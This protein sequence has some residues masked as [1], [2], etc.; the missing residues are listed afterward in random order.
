MT[1]DD[2]RSLKPA[3][4]RLSTE[5]WIGRR[6]PLKLSCSKSVSSAADAMVATRARHTT[7]RVI[8]IEFPYHRHSI[9]TPL[10]AIPCTCTTYMQGA[11]VLFLS[12]LLSAA[13]IM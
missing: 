9:G 1:T 7:H 12:S 4:A 6:R 3:L 10:R 5:L 8:F 11:Y 2:A 13:N